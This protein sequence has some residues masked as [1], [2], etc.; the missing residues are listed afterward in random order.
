[1]WDMMRGG[2]WRRRLLETRF[3]VEQDSEE[4]VVCEKHLMSTLRNGE[5]DLRWGGT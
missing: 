5:G 3:G 2:I 4:P 1:V